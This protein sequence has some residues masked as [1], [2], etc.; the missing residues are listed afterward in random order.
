M[1]ETIG[2]RSI[3]VLH[4]DDDP[5]FRGLVEEYLERID[6]NVTVVTVAEPH[7]V[8]ERLDA[9][10]FDCVVSDYQM[11]RM[12]GLELLRSV[13]QEYPNLPFVLFTGKGSEEIASEAIRAGVTHD[14]QKNGAESYELLANQVRNLV[15]Q[16]RAEHR[17]KIARNRLL[18]LYEQTDGFYSLD[19]DWEITYWNGQIADRIG[20]RPDDVIGREFW[21]V[22]PEAVDTR[23]HDRFREA[24]RTGENVEFEIEYEPH[25]YWA[26]IRAYPVDGVLFVHS[27]DVSEDKERERELQYR[28]ELLESFAS[29]VSHDLRNP[30]NVA[31]GNLQLAQETGDFDHLEE[32]AQAHNRMRNLIDELLHVARGDELEI[33]RI[34]LEGITDRAWDTV[35]TDGTTLKVDGDV[36]FECYESQ[37]RRLFENLF[38]NAIDHG[39]ARIIEVG[40]LADGFYVED[41]GRGIPPDER[42]RVFESGFS[43]D[44][45]SP[46]YGL[47]I[48]HGIV[49]IHGWDVDV[50]TGEDGGARFE[51]TD[52]EV[53]R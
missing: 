31:E 12:D 49:D 28:N 4:V 8:V 10:S 52:V 48:V 50:V 1:T 32:V 16:R 15:D 42:D 45:Q 53:E 33:S 46:G 17:A 35:T 22:F 24:M 37:L 41:D 20:R 11:P 39:S 38:W 30:L 29:T 18:E 14:L 26:E 19:E 2:E 40:P 23:I 21:E 9:G 47:S 36:Q 43:T 34:S 44:E 51:I 7:E 6:E 27:R 3:R 25:G 5:G 13:R